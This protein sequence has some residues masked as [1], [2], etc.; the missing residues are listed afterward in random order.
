[1][2]YQSLMALTFRGKIPCLVFL[3][4]LQAVFSPH[5][6]GRVEAFPKV[7]DS[8]LN[9]IIYP[10]FSPLFLPDTLFRG[11][12]TLE[13]DTDTCRMRITFLSICSVVQ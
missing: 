5:M 2:K 13:F 3:F 9:S 11:L 10:E 6:W 7:A 1:M 8:Q 4:V 12:T